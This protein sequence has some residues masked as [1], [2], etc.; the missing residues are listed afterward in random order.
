MFIS[1]IDDVYLISAGMHCGPGARLVSCDRFFNHISRMDPLIKAQFRR[2]QNLNQ[3]VLEKFVGSEPVFVVISFFSAISCMN[4]LLSL[5]C[6]YGFEVRL[7]S[8]QSLKYIIYFQFIAFCLSSLISNPKWR[9]GD[10]SLLVSLE[11]VTWWDNLGISH[12]CNLT[13]KKTTEVILVYQ[14][15]TANVY[16]VPL[17]YLFLLAF[18]SNNLYSFPPIKKE[19]QKATENI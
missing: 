2:W 11:G 8:W 7:D 16:Y 6:H 1:S 15:Y 5:R 19:Q 4:R 10:K 14:C 3:M 17:N 13:L 12:H 18:S 9:L